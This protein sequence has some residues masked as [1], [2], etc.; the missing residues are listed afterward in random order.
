[1]LCF[2]G[3]LFK[4]QLSDRIFEKLA[5]SGGPFETSQVLA[6]RDRPTQEA[7]LSRPDPRSSLA[8]APAK[9]PSSEPRPRSGC[10]ACGSSPARS[11]RSGATRGDLC[12]LWATR[13]R[14]ASGPRPARRSGTRRRARRGR[15]GAGEPDE[16]VLCSGALYV[17]DRLQRGPALRHRADGLP[18]HDH[19]RHLGSAERALR[20]ALPPR[21]GSP[22]GAGGGRFGRPWCRRTPRVAARA[23]SQRES[24]PEVYTPRSS[25]SAP[26]R[27]APV[28]DAWA[29]PTA[30][31]AG[32]PFWVYRVCIAVKSKSRPSAI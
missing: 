31:P 29:E 16:R 20:L 27:S 13:P 15:V 24:A 17:A 32:R 23:S 25:P 3:S 9:L 5:L 4:Q 30:L 10:P 22:R 8:E 2:W 19:G 26:S 12:S 14:A 11:D 21:E 7:R 18:R 28:A 6:L 1:M